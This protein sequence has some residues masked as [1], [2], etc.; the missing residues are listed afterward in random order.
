MPYG[1][2]G[3]FTFKAPSDV[4]SYTFA[5]P[6]TMN[7]SSTY[8]TLERS[9][10]GVLRFAA[11]NGYESAVTGTGPVTLGSGVGL[12]ANSKAANAKTI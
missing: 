3:V 7:S 1:A 6:D 10:A 4:Q 2:F 8:P 5:V 11:M 9:N 12:T